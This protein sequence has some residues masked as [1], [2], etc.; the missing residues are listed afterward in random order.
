[1]PTQREST[2]SHF[3]PMGSIWYRH[4]MMRLSKYGTW[5]R[6]KLCTPCMAMKVLLRQQASHRWATSSFQEAMTKILSSGSQIWT[7]DRL[8]FFMELNRRKSGPI[9]LSQIKQVLEI[10]QTI[11]DAILELDNERKTYKQKQTCRRLWSM[12]D[13]KRRLKLKAQA[14]QKKM[15][16]F[17]AK[18]QSVR[19]T[20]CS[21]QKSKI[22][23]T[24]SCTNLIY[25]RTH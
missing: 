18:L 3:T 23:W 8:R 10:C 5:E 4:L 13:I 14:S 1:M 16:K 7:S 9:F 17:F 19:P 25:A 12:V 11:I 22:V 20:I 6:V 2:L 21:N 24:K 15:T